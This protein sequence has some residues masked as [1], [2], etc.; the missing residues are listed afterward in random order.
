VKLASHLSCLTLVVAGSQAVAL[1][2]IV[3]SARQVESPLFKADG[4]LVTLRPR[5][6]GRAA[7]E[8]RAARVMFSGPLGDYRDLRLSCAS[9]DLTGPAP[10]C[11][12]L[13]I[14]SATSPLGPLRLSAQARYHVDKEIFSFDGRGWQLA[15]GMATVAARADA[16]NWSAKLHGVG[17]QARPLQKLLKPYASPP[18]DF[19]TAG[20]FDFDA[21]LGGTDGTTR[22]TWKL[23]ASGVEFTNPDATIIGE[24]LV[25]SLGGNVEWPRGRDIM[26]QTTEFAGTSGQALLGPA[27][28]DLQKN[29]LTASGRGDYDGKQL[30]FSELRLRQPELLEAEGNL[31]LRLEPDFALDS[32]VVRITRLEFPA[33]YTSLIQL[34]AA[35]TVFGD[36]RTTGE[37]SGELWLANNAVIRVDFS[38]RG[39][40]L[41]DTKGKFRMA[42]L[43]GD[44]HWRETAQADAPAS[45]L[46]WREGGS[47]GLSGGAARIDFAAAGRG[48]A[49]T[50]PT[51]IPIFDGGL[52]IKL[53]SVNNIG[54]DSM[55][56]SFE[57]D[58][59]PIGMPKISKA[60][61][62]PELAGTLGGRIPR[63][64]Y[65]D[66]L[67][68]FSGDVVAQVFAGRIVG[69]NMKLQDP[70]G[71]WPRFFADIRLESL[72]LAMVTD[73]FSIGSIT[74]RLEGQIRDMELFNWSP[75]KFDAALGT[76]RGDKGPHRISAKAVGTLSDIGNNGGGGFAKLQS[77]LLQFFDEYDYDR[78]GIRC[79]LA[80][81]TCNMSGIERAGIGYYILQGKGLPHIDIVGNAGR[82]NWPSLVGQISDAMKNSGS[83]IKIGK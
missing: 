5:D 18:D 29:P 20:R 47:Y 69:S 62:W 32:G 57:G 46:S 33:A 71:P 4:V 80:N 9:V 52:N 3:F 41:E 36:L 15:G 53:L 42:G 39:L 24:K 12:S 83:N 13:N 61:G 74:G 6:S 45:W 81:E 1:E 44:L 49:L 11:D 68:T 76:P 78:I 50:K 10:L 2:T 28:L 19:E 82:V 77:G 16:R 22:G 17:M 30:R 34:A 37:A 64:D 43:Q 58:I 79:Q 63:V 67:V 8:M 59:Q 40:D 21:S 60:F 56:G 72:D 25:F 75:V 7:L 48:F 55:Q 27:L 38:T 35:A 65:R 31:S 26:L 66:K 23:L 14:A 51:R 70:L 73:T 54:L